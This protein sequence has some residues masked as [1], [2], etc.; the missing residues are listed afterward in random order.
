MTDLPSAL[1]KLSESDR[2]KALEDLVIF[3]NYFIYEREDGTAEL[4]DPTRLQWAVTKVE[5]P[6]KFP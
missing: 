1:M 6:V 5:A 4:L 2:Q 3:G